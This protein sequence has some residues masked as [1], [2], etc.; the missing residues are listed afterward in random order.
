MASSSRPLP[1]PHTKHL[2]VIDY[3]LT[4]SLS[5]SLAQSQSNEFATTGTTLWLSGQVLSAYLLDT[6][7]KGKGKANLGKRCIELGSGVGL[8]GLALSHLS[9]DVLTTDVPFIL[10]SVLLPNLR[11]NPTSTL[12]HAR[13]LDWTVPSSEWD[14][15]SDGG[16]TGTS[17]SSE[18]IDPSLLPSELVNPTAS[19][20]SSTN[21][22]Q[23]PFSLI[24]TTDTLYTPALLP[25]LLNTLRDLS[26]LSLNV[27]LPA[28]PILL[29]L[30]RRDTNLIDTALERAKEEGF[31]V[32]MVNKGRVSKSVERWLG[33]ER[34]EWEGVEVWKLRWKGKG[35][36]GKGG[37]VGEG[38]RD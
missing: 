37:G 15:S 8:V 26:L 28:P 2:P 3:P 27:D 12:L 29:A 35:K 20:S 7:E 16:G 14:W 25:H 18:W 24:I 9:F 31:E 10:S 4:P 17:V 5:L 19:P 34:E 30:E 33:W 6:Y 23:P 11:R 13:E 38:E 1:S 21:T 36:S 22:I 32:K